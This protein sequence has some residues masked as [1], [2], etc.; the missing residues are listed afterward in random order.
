MTDTHTD[1]LT[2]PPHRFMHNTDPSPATAKKTHRSNAKKNNVKSLERG[3]TPPR[4]TS[5]GGT[6]RSSPRKKVNKNNVK[7]NEGNGK[8]T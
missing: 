1:R 8:Y 4:S 5:M 3:K 7:G 2:P 6:G